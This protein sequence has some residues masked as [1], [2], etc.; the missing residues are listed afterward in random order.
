[1]ESL[2]EYIYVDSR[3]RDSNLFPNGNTYS[4]YL[5]NPIKNIKSVDL[6]S[7]SV[8]N[9]IYNLTFG[10]NV[11]PALLGKLTGR[12]K[13]DIRNF[14]GGRQSYEDFGAPTATKI[15]TDPNAGGGDMTGMSEILGK[16]LELQQRT[17]DNI[18]EQ[19]ETKNNFQEEREMEAKKRHD[20]LLNAI[21]GFKPE[22]KP[23]RKYSEGEEDDDDGYAYDSSSV[24]PAYPA[25]GMGVYATNV[26]HSGIIRGADT[27]SSNMPS[28]AA[29]GSQ[30]YSNEFPK[31]NNIIFFYIIGR[32]G[33]FGR[34]SRSFIPLF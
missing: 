30:N 1:M 6:V 22:E 7:A 4:V 21:R 32:N 2:V 31:P 25:Q 28:S 29:S 17:Y 19:R 24:L 11:A 9:T 12:S 18:K 34:G 3:T 13:A 23:K 14:T 10:S 26:S 33:G 5:A 8:P 20:D 27:L 16:I 15:G